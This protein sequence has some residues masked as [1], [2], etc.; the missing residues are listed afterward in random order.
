MLFVIIVLVFTGILLLPDTNGR[1]L[2]HDINDWER[3]MGYKYPYR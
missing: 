2:E 1:Q 3:I